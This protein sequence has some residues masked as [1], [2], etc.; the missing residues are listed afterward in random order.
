M[1]KAAEPSP[2]FGDQQSSSL[3][4]DVLFT[5][6]G[7]L[8]DAI[9]AYAEKINC[10][11]GQEILLQDCRAFYYVEQ[12]I[13]EV[14]H[15]A[16]ETRITVALLGPGEFFG[17]IGFFDGGSR[18]RDIRATKDAEI[19]RFDLD[20]VEK[21][22]HEKPELYGRLVTSLTKLIC[23]KFRRV[24]E[25]NEPLIGYA[26]SLSTKRRGFTESRPLPGRLLK[27]PAW[28]KVSSEVESLK[29]ELFDIS[30]Q[31]QKDSAA[32]E[33]DRE[34]SGKCFVILDTINENLARY[35]EMMKT[36]EDQDLMWGF[37][38]K[39]VFPYIMRSRFVERAYYK[40]KGYAGDFLMMEHIYRDTPEGDGRLGRIVDAWCLQ[41]PG[42]KAIRGRRKLLSAQLASLTGSFRHNG[43]PVRIMNLACGPNRELFDFLSTCAYSQAIEALCVDIDLE[44]LQYTNLHVNIFPHMAAIRLMNENLVKWALG[45]VRHEIGKQHIIYSA[46]L[47]DYLD[48][49]L[50]QAMIKRCHEHLEPGGKL[51][52]GNFAPYPDQIFM[53]EILHWELLYRTSDDLAD[54]FAGTPFGADIDIISE[55]EGVNLFVLATKQS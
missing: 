38:F 5:V 29:A 26:A 46:G 55:E 11:A 3:G 30:Y 52:L 42:A 45:R 23:R 31:L 6:N 53:D 28:H 7:Q 14:S 8:N 50:F 1:Y 2:L 36:Q 25:E 40:P 12:G 43:S 44:A 51:L 20:V 49:R 10:A 24:L 48:R 16:D 17:E 41:R 4:D 19:C 34:I 13:I 47:C 54:I 18:V 32:A 9:L 33:P 21:L 35:K 27:R 37:I 15:T 39:E 22:Y